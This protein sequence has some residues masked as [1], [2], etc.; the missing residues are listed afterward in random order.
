MPTCK[1]CYRIHKIISLTG[2]DSLVGRRW[3][4]AKLAL[5]SFFEWLSMSD[6]ISIGTAILHGPTHGYMYTSF[7]KRR[8]PRTVGVS[9][10]KVQCKTPPALKKNNMRDMKEESTW[11]EERKTKKG[12]NNKSLDSGGGGGESWL[13]NAWSIIFLF[14]GMSSGKSQPIR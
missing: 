4:I 14:L 10:L 7:D 1:A 8:N 5:F 13:A 2:R 9:G 3:Q 11:K 12:N 6:L